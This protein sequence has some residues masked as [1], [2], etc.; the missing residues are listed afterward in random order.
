MTELMSKQKLGKPKEKD[1]GAEFKR[2]ENNQK[3]HE[4]VE[5]TV[6]MRNKL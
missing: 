3:I 4:K 2:R 1:K 5:I 6:G